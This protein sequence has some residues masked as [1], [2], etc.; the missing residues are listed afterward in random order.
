MLQKLMQVLKT[1]CGS[2]TVS[3]SFLKFAASGPMLNVLQS[4]YFC[5]SSL[6]NL[7]TRVSKTDDRGAF[8]RHL[9]VRAALKSNFWLIS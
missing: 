2:S 8:Q 3:I 9:A 6:T 4:L 1:K 5:S 7:S